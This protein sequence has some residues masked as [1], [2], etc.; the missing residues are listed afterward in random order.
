MNLNCFYGKQS[1]SLLVF[2]S[3]QFRYDTKHD[4]DNKRSKIWRT[5][6][7]IDYFGDN[8]AFQFARL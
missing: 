4:S 6:D 1:N 2:Q 8:S 5:V 7:S 3:L